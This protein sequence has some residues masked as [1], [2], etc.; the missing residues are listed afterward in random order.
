VWNIFLC[1]I[2][3]AGGGGGGGGLKT[4]PPPPPHTRDILATSEFRIF[5]PLLGAFASTLGK[6][7]ASSCLSL[8]PS[9]LMHGTAGVPLDVFSWNLTC[10]FFRKSVE[11][12]QVS[13]KLRRIEGHWNL[14]S[15][16]FFRKSVEKIQVSLKLRRI[17]GHFTW[18]TMYICDSISL[19]SS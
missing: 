17:E 15:V 3:A 2:K 14:T 7:T 8:H 11:K 1:S 10:F 13:L 16:F 6:V 4:P 12:I 9:A 19:D 5:Y 18:R